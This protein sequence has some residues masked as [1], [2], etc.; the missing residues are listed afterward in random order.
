MDLRVY[1]IFHDRL[2]S[3]FYILFR[4][5]GQRILESFCRGY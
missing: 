2:A 4:I 1:E 5:I 3:F